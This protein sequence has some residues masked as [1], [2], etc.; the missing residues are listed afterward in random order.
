MCKQKKEKNNYYYI[1]H[2]IS[3]NPLI[4]KKMLPVFHSN[5]FGAKLWL[6]LIIIEQLFKFC[7]ELFKKQI[8]MLL[9]QTIRML[10]LLQSLK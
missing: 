10:P 2:F 5:D 9:Y 7:C 4:L 6:D 8:Q 3:Q 1:S